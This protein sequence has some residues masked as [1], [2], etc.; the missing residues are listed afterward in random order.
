MKYLFYFTVISV[1]IINSSCS[2]I[3][4]EK[5]AIK[6]S[7]PGTSI[8]LNNVGEGKELV[9]LEDSVTLMK[10]I[11]KQII[12]VSK[13]GFETQTFGFR[14]VSVGS[15]V[16]K[17]IMGAALGGSLLF[18]GLIGT[19]VSAS[20]I[21]GT[22]PTRFIVPALFIGI[23]A[24]ILIPTAVNS[25]SG[26]E[27]TFTYK[28]IEFDMIPIPKKINSD[29]V[30]TISCNSVSYKIKPGT[31]LGSS[32]VPGRKGFEKSKDILWEET[33]NVM[34]TE[35][36]VLVNNDLAD[37]GYP[38]PGLKDKFKN[39]IDKARYTISPE[40]KEVKLEQY[41]YV[42]RVTSSHISGSTVLY[43]TTY[44]FDHFCTL[45]ITWYVYDNKKGKLVYEETN[46]TS[47]LGNDQSIKLILF[48][49]LSGSLKK[50]MV[51]SAF[52][53][54]IKKDKQTKTTETI[55]PSSPINIV[56]V[57]SASSLSDAVE[58]TITI[59]LGNNGHGSG[60]IISSDGY[61]ITNNHVI[62][63]NKVVT[64]ILS[65]GLSLEAE[66]IRT[67]EKTDVALIKIQGKGF[68]SISLNLNEVGVGSNI[69][70]IGTPG[71]KE[72]G[73]TISKGIISGKRQIENNLFLQTDVSIS[74]GSSGGPA[75]NEQNEVIG[76]ITSKLIGE[77]IEGVGF[78]IPI[79][80]ALSKLG[81]VVK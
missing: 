8:K 17:N 22:K 5:I 55:Q 27:Y 4:Y 79:K 72:L 11:D 57:K 18:G 61:A 25:S 49:A 54:E 56:S 65:N 38:V 58:S 75:I 41:S 23:G 42:S 16:G 80:T 46:A 7:Q 34:D 15:S 60:F 29:S 51:N 24:A 43:E 14:R 64:V 45:K 13:P 30:E 10:K 1:L 28:S 50:L 44:T 26:A 12:E 2:R 35:L 77:G 81:I 67:D 20:G 47:V 53:K 66:V 3:A 40:I 48:K 73:Q 70:A 62:E 63:G 37:L 76:I 39:N 59:D 9:G 21:G 19:A 33:S 69:M 32:F 78:A 52:P 68:K 36:E 31:V 6:S 74:P 71:K